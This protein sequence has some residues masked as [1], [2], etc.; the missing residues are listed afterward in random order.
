MI[1]P[2]N[3]GFQEKSVQARDPHGPG[4]PGAIGLTG[5]VRSLAWQAAG[6]LR[7]KI[8]VFCMG[9]SWNFIL[10][11]YSIELRYIYYIY[12][13]IYRYILSY[14]FCLYIEYL[15]HWSGPNSG[16]V[17]HNSLPRRITYKQI[18]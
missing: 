5:T 14:I 1:F 4:T 13:Y 16:L 17:T 15:D 6:D 18:I 2:P 7:R 11:I 8:R 9:K 3:W 12:I 10:I